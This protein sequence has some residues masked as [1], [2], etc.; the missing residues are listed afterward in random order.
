MITC[1]PDRVSPR[2][3]GRVQ[4]FCIIH[5]ESAGR[6]VGPIRKGSGREPMS[7]N[8]RQE[9]SPESRETISACGVEKYGGVSAHTYNAGSLRV[10]NPCGQL[11]KE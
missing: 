6:S 3:R 7:T 11:K 8:E 10:I 5:K 1:P 9:V 4:L 2:K